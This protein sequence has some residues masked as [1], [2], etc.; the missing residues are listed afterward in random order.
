MITTYPSA[1]GCTI[2]M[3]E[4]TQYTL[5]HVISPKYSAKMDTRVSW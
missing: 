1:E 5:L 2:I 4:L 3:D